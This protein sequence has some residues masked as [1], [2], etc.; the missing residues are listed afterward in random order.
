MRNLLAGLSI[1]FVLVIFEEQSYSSEC[2]A[3][4]YGYVS[5]DSTVYYWFDD[6]NSERPKISE[7]KIP[8]ADAESFQSLKDPFPSDCPKHSTFYGKDKSH[9]YYRGEIVKG[10]DPSTFSIFDRVYVKDKS[11]VFY[12]T[13]LLSN[14]VESFHRVSPNGTL[15]YATDGDRYYYEDIVIEGKSFGSF[16]FQGYQYARIDNRI[17]HEGK[18]VNGADVETFDVIFPGDKIGKD[19]NHVFYNDIVIVG[20]DPKT[21]GQVD[22]ADGVF[23]LAPEKRIPC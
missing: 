5:K 6:L 10:A 4:T 11:H 13:K 3:E 23:E 12:G 22:K 14:R 2:G 19:K 15:R 9:V 1:I 17:Y 18:P 16:D 20:A 21:F 7:K 8:E